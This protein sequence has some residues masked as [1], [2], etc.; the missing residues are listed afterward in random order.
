MSLAEAVPYTTTNHNGVPY[1]TTTNHSGITPSNMTN[2]TDKQQSSK[3]S[4]NHIDLLLDQVRAEASFDGLLDDID[5]SD[6]DSYTEVQLGEAHEP[7]NEVPQFVLDRKKKRAESSYVPIK[8]P[9][10]DNIHT[11]LNNVDG[12]ATVN[13]PPNYRRG[14]FDWRVLLDVTEYEL[15]QA[16]NYLL[17]TIV[18]NY[19][20]PK[21]DVSK[22]LPEDLAEELL[23][24]KGVFDILI[25]DY[26]KLHLVSK[27]NEIF[28]DKMYDTLTL[29]GKDVNITPIPLTQK[30]KEVFIQNYQ[31]KVRDVEVRRR[32]N[33]KPA[34]YTIGDIVG[35]QDKEGKWWMS[36]VLDVFSHLDQHMYYV[37]FLGWGEQFNEFIVSPFK[38]Q[39][40]NPKRHRYYRPAFEKKK[41]EEGNE[42]DEEND[43][44]EENDDEESADNKNDDSTPTE[45]GPFKAV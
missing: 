4:Y 25:V 44:T 42:E 15:V 45:V 19:S 8:V 39:R 41:D 32:L 10:I 11:Y 40:F 5:K 13:D 30:E 23:I 36:Q 33:A 17:E 31:K 12:F 26:N 24:L 27:Y 14:M 3:Q 38:I 6:N 21:C 29:T 20:L 22:T 35:A 7:R 16:R 1:T 2:P 18:M 37:T 43:G 28:N 9:D 34:K